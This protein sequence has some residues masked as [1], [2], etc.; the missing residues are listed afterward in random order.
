MFYRIKENRIYDYADYEYAKDCLC[1]DLCTMEEFERNKDNYTCENGILEL[2]PNIDEVIIQRR[3][4]QFYKDFFQTSL[5]NI[6]RKVQMK[7][8][9]VKDFLSDLLLQ[10]KA[11]IE[12]GQ[13]VEILTY[14]TPDFTQELTNEYMLSLQ[15]RK[16]ADL[17]FV[18]EC[19][20][21]TVNDFGI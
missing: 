10:I 19:L 5:G 21:Q 2:I 17:N 18:R 12:L 14:E 8:G 7:D 13:N 6:R 16:N 3:R 9:T 20:M 1:T 11:G 4:R 15:E